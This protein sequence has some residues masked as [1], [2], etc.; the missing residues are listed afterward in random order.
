M[1]GVQTCALP[2]SMYLQ[3]YQQYQTV[4]VATDVSAKTLAYVEENQDMFP[5]LIINT[6]SLRE[7]PQGEQFAHIVGYI[8]QMT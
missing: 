2:I 6:I 1:T 4:N 3:R 5:C 8:L 7:Y